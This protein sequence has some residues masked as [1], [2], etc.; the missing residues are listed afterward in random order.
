MA[1]STQVAVQAAPAIPDDDAIARAAA[2]TREPFVLAGEDAAVALAAGTPRRRAFDAAVAEIEEGAKVPSVGW[3][4]RWSLLLGL[5]RLLSEEEPR[6]A[7]GTL[8]SAHQ[9]DALSG[10]LT[11]LLAESGNGNGNGNGAV[12]AQDAASLASAGIPGEEGEDEDEPEEP[13]DWEDEAPPEDNGEEQ[14][15]E[16]P[17]DPNAAKRFWFEHATGAGKTVAALGFVEGSRTGGILI[18]THRR[19]L[20]DQFLGELRD[21]GYGKRIAPPLVRG[22]DRADGP[23]TVETYQW[24]VRNAGNVSDAY[25][26]VICD[27]AHTALGEK[28]SASIRNWHEPVFVGMTATGALIA[29]HVTDLFPT[30]TSRFDL[31]QA[32]RRGVIAP[33]RC[34]RIPPGPGVRTIAKV[35]LRRGEVDTEFDQEL[36]AELL[37]QLP[38]NLAVADLYK[39]RFNGVPGVVYAAGVRHAYNVAEAFRDVGLKAQAVSGET[40]KRELAQI[41]AR[42]ERGEVDVLVNA[43]LLAEG[44]NSPR[45]T[46]CMHL[47]PTASRRIYQQRVG[48]VTRRHPGKE[49]G[50]VVDFV[51][52]ATKHDD[53]VV[54]L[55]SLLDREVYRGGAIVVGPVRRGRGRRLRVE[56]R[57]LPVTA[58]EN[59]RI[60]VFERELWRIA[61]EHLDYGEQVQ[62]AALAGARVAPAGW[63]RAR[64]MLHFDQGGE[65][66][67][68]FL[69][70]AVDRNKNAQLRL[71]ALQEIAASRDAEAFDRALDFVESWPRDD[72]REG[73]KAV[74]Q[75]LAEKKVGRRDQANNWIWRCANMTREVHEEYA[76][77]RWPETKRLLGLLVNSSGGA[78][79]RNARRLVH[80]ARQQD[81][82][83]SA[84]LLAAAIPHT[85][86]AGE[87]INGARTRMSR[88]PAA[89][90][91]ELLRNFPKGKGRRGTRRRKKKGAEGVAPEAALEVAVA[92]GLLED[93]EAVETTE[94]K[95]VT[96]SDSPLMAAAA[97]VAAAA[98]AT[99]EEAPK[100]PRRRSVMI[101]PDEDAKPA[102]RR[103]AK[104]APA[105][106]ASAETPADETPKPARRRRARKADAD[107]PAADATT[108][109]PADAPKPRRRR[110]AKPAAEARRAR[111]R[112]PEAASPAHDEGHR[113]RYR[114]RRDPGARRGAE[115]RA[116]PP[117]DEGGERATRHANG[118]TPKPRRRSTK[119]PSTSAAAESASRRGAVTAAVEAALDV[120][121]EPAGRTKAADPEAGDSRRRAVRAAE[122]VIADGEPP[123]PRP[124]RRTAKAPEAA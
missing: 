41:L 103:R 63:R 11:A 98:S 38:F 32:A 31:A 89:L 83:L 22:Q 34:V 19:N 15:P 56:R 111:R 57:V 8:L 3:R 62:W 2:F 53:P 37:D 47:A 61:V 51:H 85:A 55:H 115:A 116:P 88:K 99:D 23:V 92:P 84:A 30:Q 48:R 9:V 80:A 78:H 76:V 10:T 13:Q 71:R 17:E 7:D 86:E 4:Q 60:E 64:A 79:A 104:P 117:H 16:A 25:T 28:T 77:Q 121:A 110:T 112:G 87:V 18:L 49:A 124:R 54:T 70:T 1:E 97:A 59:R 93:G 26:I 20:V 46:V 113:D 50:I 101:D 42:Y 6:L 114:G 45:A 95:P 40:P 74:L 5:D 90:A 24:F 65:L 39:T 100:R 94:R 81:R 106:A 21:R 118:D 12:S 14:L 67:R 69:I 120:P 107:T 68:T 102:R 119:T 75:A 109:T 43:Q 35:P 105:D 58:D 44:W 73:V 27:E 82:R 108:E 122:E 52:P 66:K 72:K 96:E 36:L 29:R 123:K 91:R 33:L